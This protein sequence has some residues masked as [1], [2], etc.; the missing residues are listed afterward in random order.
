MDVNTRITDM[1]GTSALMPSANPAASTSPVS[2]A[3]ALTPSISAMATNGK[4]ILQN[5]SKLAETLQ[6]VRDE[7][8]V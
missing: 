8:G 7:L 1:L 5:A 4:L 3:T 6:Q 2:T